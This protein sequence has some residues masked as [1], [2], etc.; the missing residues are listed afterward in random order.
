[1]K[2]GY[3][4]LGEQLKRNGIKQSWLAE[5]L[6]VHK[7]QVTR[8]VKGINEPSPKNYKKIIRIIGI[9]K[10]RKKLDLAE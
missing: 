7:N 2:S 8:W 1:M 5:Q 6:G 3:T 9:I 10:G 4:K